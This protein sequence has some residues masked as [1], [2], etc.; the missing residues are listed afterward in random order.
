MSQWIGAAVLVAAAQWWAP[1]RRRERA[2]VSAEAEQET[3]PH[4]QE[5]PTGVSEMDAS[6]AKER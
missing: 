6:R 2:S 5:T 1:G 4:G 3:S